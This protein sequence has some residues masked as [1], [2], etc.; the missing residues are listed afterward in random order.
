MTKF[1]WLIHK[2]NED[3]QPHKWTKF[4]SLLYFNTKFFVTVLIDLVIWNITIK[5]KLLKWY[6]THKL[7][8]S[9]PKFSSVL[10]YLL[11]LSRYQPLPVWVTKQEVAK[12]LRQSGIYTSYFPLRIPNFRPFCS[13]SYHYRDISHFLLEWRN[14]KWRKICVKAVYTLYT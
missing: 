11:P 8:P 6:T 3:K 12:N 2:C 9:G 10:L 13:I 4:H 1:I 7:N 14:R 5:L